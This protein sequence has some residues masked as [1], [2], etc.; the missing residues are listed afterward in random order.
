MHPEFYLF[1]SKIVRA[2]VFSMCVASVLLGHLA[3]ACKY[4][5]RDVAFVDLTQESYAFL[6]ISSGSDLDA[7]KARI[8]PVATAS[9]DDNHPVRIFESRNT[10]V[11]T[12]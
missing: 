10:A 8:Q 6:T 9:S 1:F 12:G 5:V 4:S 11:A 2:T 7:I 3:H